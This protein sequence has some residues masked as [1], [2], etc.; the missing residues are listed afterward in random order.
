MS[1][2]IEIVRRSCLP[3]VDFDRPPPLGTILRIEY[4][5]RRCARRFQLIGIQ[6][7]TRKDGQES[8]ILI[9]RAER[10]G[11]L[12]TTGL[13]SHGFTRGALGGWEW[14]DGLSD[15]AFALI[16]IPPRFGEGRFLGADSSPGI[17]NERFT[18]DDV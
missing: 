17:A 16:G 7:Y 9:W 4:Q 8:W 3:R 18:D 14:A 2:H 12:L 11:A 13:Q 10:D 5:R 6:P 15:T 1:S